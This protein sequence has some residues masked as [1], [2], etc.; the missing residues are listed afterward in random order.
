MVHPRTSSP[1]IQSKIRTRY[2]LRSGAIEL[3]NTGNNTISHNQIQNVPRFGIADFQSNGSIKTG[4]NIIEYNTILNSGQATNDTGAIYAYSGS[5]LSALGDTIAYNTINNAGGLGT[6]GS[7]FNAGQ[8]WSAGIYM[9]EGVNGAQIYGNVING[10]TFGGVFLHGGSNNSVWENI[11]TGTN[12][13]PGINGGVGVSLVAVNGQPMTG[14]TIHNNIIELPASGNTI[15]LNAGTAAPSSTFQNIYYNASGTPPL[16][17]TMTF[18]Q[19]LASIGD[20]GSTVTSNPGFENTA[21]NDY[22]LMA[23]SYALTHGFVDLPW[24]QMALVG[25]QNVAAAAPSITS[26]SA[27]S[28]VVGDHITNDNTLTLTGTA[29]ANSTVKI[30]DGAT[31][32]GTATAAANGTWS[33]TT[34]ALTNG[35]H[36]FTATDTDAAGNTSAASAALS[37]TIDTTAPIAPAIASFST[38]SGVVGDH[39]TNDKTL[40]LTGTAEANSTVNV[41][42]GATKIGSRRPAQ[43]VRGVSSPPL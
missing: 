17:G 27:D 18:G 11:I 5:D 13:L 31:L 10:T 15:W 22:K 41:Y 19:Y 1:K 7:G 39:I 42:D 12:A 32:L 33:F 38:D 29:E 37:V 35:A 30:F 20:Q 21:I 4:A 2:L 14:N 43:T 9:D 16:M 6:T 26:F 34:A 23:G 24:A 3:E 28:G 25:P 8:Y 40:T 36:S